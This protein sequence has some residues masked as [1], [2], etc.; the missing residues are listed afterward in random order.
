MVKKV[1]IFGG[2]IGGL[3]VAHELAERG[4]FEITIYEKS[5]ACGGKAKSTVTEHG[6]PAEHSIRTISHTYYH[7]RNTLKRIPTNDGK[8]VFDNVVEPE[9]GSRKYLLFK[10][11]PACILPT[12]FPY[13]WSG[14]KELFSFIRDMAKIVPY[15][16]INNFMYKIILSGSMCTE[17]RGDTLEKISWDQY[18]G[19]D[20]MSRNYQYYLHRL[21]EFYVAAKGSSNAKSMSMLV[22]KSLFIPLIHPIASQHSSHDYFNGPTSEILINPW[23]NHIKKLGVTIKLHCTAEKIDIK[24]NEIQSVTVRSET[25]ETIQADYYVFAVPVEVMASLITEPMKKAAPSLN[26]ID[27]LHTEESSGIQF[28]Y[29]ESL[30]EKLPKGWMA[31]MDSPWSLIG[32]YLEGANFNL[33]SP[34]KSILSLTWSNFDLPGILYNKPARECTAEEIKNEVLAQVSESQGL[35]FLRDVPMHSYYIDHELEFSKDTGVLI[36]QHTPL[37]VQLPNDHQNQPESYTEIKN[38]FLAADYV[39]TSY[40]LATMESA[41]EAGRKAVNAILKADGDIAKPCFVKSEVTT[42]FGALQSFD[43]IIYKIQKMFTSGKDHANAN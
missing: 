41:N 19:S 18:I 25:E 5:S 8:T 21:P 24:N 34:V 31:F 27:K 35:E 20:K 6:C 33:P 2:G 42:G 32:L 23:V 17:R 40:D 28:Y 43:K 13:N 26:F 9:G 14:F 11:Y 22:E 36:K 38:L 12:Y 37:F 15:S 4:G 29:T 7:F 3:T 39:R 10:N 1:A 16:E 30:K